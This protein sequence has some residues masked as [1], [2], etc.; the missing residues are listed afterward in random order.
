MVENFPAMQNRVLVS[1][2]KA[3]A[4]YLPVGTDWVIIRSF[5]AQALV[6]VR[7]QRIRRNDVGAI[8]SE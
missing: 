6:S 4:F 2:G 5:R 8:T 3:R 1:G 7:R